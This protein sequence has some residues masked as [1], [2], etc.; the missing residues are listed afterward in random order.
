VDET[1][2]DVYV[3]RVRL[4]RIL[5]TALVVPLSL[6]R[7]FVLSLLWP[8][9]YDGTQVAPEWVLVARKSDGLTVARVFA[10]RELGDGDNLLAA[11]TATLNQ[12]GPA[13]FLDTWHMTRV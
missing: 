7:N 6:L 13:E 2:A 4:G 8:W 5:P 9:G 11:M 12:L 3:L 10:G 1:A